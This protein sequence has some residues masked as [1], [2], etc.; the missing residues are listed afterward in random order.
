MKKKWGHDELMIDL[1]NHLQRPER[2]V[3]TDMQ[4]GPS[5]SPR[6]DVYTIQK[7][8]VKPKP[9]SYEIKVSISDFRSDITKGKW[10]SYLDFSSAVIFCVPKGLIGKE[11]LPVGCG[12]MFRGES[13]WRTVKG[14]TL[15][16]VKLGEK[17]LMKLLIDGVSRASQQNRIRDFNTYTANQEIKKELGELVSSA[18]SDRENMLSDAR[19]EAKRIVHAAQREELLIKSS[20]E[21]LQNKAKE[22]E[23]VRSRALGELADVLGVDVNIGEWVIIN[24]AREFKE[25]NGADERLR[26]AQHNLSRLMDSFKR[27]FG[28]FEGLISD[29]GGEQ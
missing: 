22:I 9:I 3:W 7:S 5:G 29:Q 19:Y 21:R 18:I 10:Q 13:G 4:M 11:D 17:H 15:N 8:Y 12:L 14:P 2:M 26:R 28:D 24:A 16:P 20:I 6:P 23:S 27:S 25:R 1:A